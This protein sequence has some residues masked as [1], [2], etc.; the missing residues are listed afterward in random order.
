MMQADEVTTREHLAVY[1]RGLADRLHAMSEEVGRY[2]TACHDAGQDVETILIN[3]DQN[4]RRL[5][6]EWKRV[7]KVLDDVYGVAADLNEAASTAEDTTTE[8]HKVANW[9]AGS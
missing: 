1:L 7:R 9:A 4:P 6:G 8:L 3:L 5:S 2:I